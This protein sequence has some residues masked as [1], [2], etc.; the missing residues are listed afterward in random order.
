MLKK[1]WAGSRRR[2][3]TRA[4][5][6]SNRMSTRR[7]TNPRT[8]CLMNLFGAKAGQRPFMSVDEHI[9]KFGDL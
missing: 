7:G 8:R 6:A 9:V 3:L 1:T 4:R 2:E 5:G